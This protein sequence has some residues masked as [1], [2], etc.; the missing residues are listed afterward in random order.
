MTDGS[1]GRETISAG[2]HLRSVPDEG[3]E[4]PELL[5]RAARGQ[6]EAFATLY[7]RTS[8]R[9]FGLVQRIVRSPEQ[10]AE[11]TQEVYL[12]AW[13]L[14]ARYDP[15]R[16]SVA[17]WLTT[18]AHRRAVDRVR[19]AQAA[20]VRDDADARAATAARDTR[21]DQVWDHVDARLD[22]ERVRRAMGSLTQLQ[23]EALVLT[24]F[25]GYTQREVA[26]MLKLPLGTAKTRIRDALIGMRD[27]LEVQG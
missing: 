20:T 22:A 24:Y 1:A 11:V 2:R 17:A 19:A 15:A 3:A 4:L 26:T 23:R 18:I 16:G 12:E 21:P 25:G 9:I 13:R 7:D 8:P 14:S 5:D 27:A 10:A 6:Q